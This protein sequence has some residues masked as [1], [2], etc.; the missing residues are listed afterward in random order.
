ME[1]AGNFTRMEFM[2]ES[3]YGMFEKAKVRIKISSLNALK[4]IMYVKYILSTRY[5]SLC[6]YVSIYYAQDKFKGA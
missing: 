1:K 2:W 5:G 3:M 6:M 4:N